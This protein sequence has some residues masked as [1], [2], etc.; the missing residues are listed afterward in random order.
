MLRATRIALTQYQPPE[1]LLTV[2]SPLPPKALP[3]AAAAT[4]LNASGNQDS[5]LG[6]LEVDLNT[7]FSDGG[8]PGATRVVPLGGP[9]M[10]RGKTL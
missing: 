2:H 7:H 8:A 5:L 9:V 1:D 4:G 6:A 3:Q 10:G